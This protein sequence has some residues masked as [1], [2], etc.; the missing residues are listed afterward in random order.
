VQES[1]YQLQEWWI[2]LSAAETLARG[3]QIGGRLT[4]GAVLV[5][6]G[7]LGSGK[8]TLIQGICRGM[9]ITETA[10]SPTFTLIN[11]YHGRLPV[12]HF[13]FYRLHSA[14]ELADLGL[15]EYLYGDGVSLVEWPELI[16][17]WLPVRHTRFQLSHGV[18]AAGRIAALREARH[19][20]PLL[21]TADVRLIEAYRHE[22]ARD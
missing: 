1:R 20:D 15:E 11:E 7:N 5:F 17:G 22:T 2:T 16:A 3:A 13:D 8:T 14:G 19:E 21:I 12:Y 18:H 10:T 9:D 4:P 6:T